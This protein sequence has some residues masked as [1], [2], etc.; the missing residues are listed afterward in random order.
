MTEKAP[1]FWLRKIAAHLQDYDQIPLFG[2][3]PSF[4]WE[5]FSS[6]AESRF[7]V[8]GLKFRPAEQQWRTSELLSEG[9]GSDAIVLPVKVGPLSGSAFWIMPKQS[10]VKLTSWM[11]NGQIKVRPLSADVLT[12]GFYRYLGLQLLDIAS[13]FEPLKK[14]TPVI[15]AHS[16]LPETDAFCIDVE[17]EFGD[18]TCWGRLAIEPELQKNAAEFFS[19]TSAPSILSSV[20]SSTELTLGIQVGSIQ[21]N[22][23][24]WDRV[25]EGDFIALD[26]GG[27]D[28]RKHQGAAYLTIGES[29]LFQIKIKQNKIQLIDY[30]FIQE[31]PMSDQNTSDSEETANFDQEPTQLS[32]ATSEA[33]SLKDIPVNLVVEL[34]RLKI[35][36]EKLMQLSPGN[37]LEIP[38]KPDQAV[39]LTVNGQQVGQG[40]LVHLG[41]TLGVRILNLN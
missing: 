1:F 41:E 39:K 35:S 20:A 26:E 4:N 32:E 27:Y 7:G 30:A 33:I 3:A 6:Q 13:H 28:A 23:S 29:T 8:S 5:E 16:Q 37:L 10:I 25:N 40:E 24:D 12:T 2:Q 11:I 34:S 21:L 22:P 36:L 18:N 14:I 17:I 9:L 19:Q 38:M 15:S 31:A